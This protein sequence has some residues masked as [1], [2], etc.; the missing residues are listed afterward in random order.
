MSFLRLP[1]LLVCLLLAAAVSGAELKIALLC[2]GSTNDGG[3]NQLAREGAERLKAELGATVTVQQRVTADTAATAMKDFASDG[4]QLVIAHGYEFLNPAAATA[5]AVGTTRIAVSGADASRPG[6]VS[7]D[8][9]V[10]QASYQLGIIAGRLSRSGKLGFIGGG[11][12]PAVK[13]C[14]RGFLAGAHS[15]RP[16]ATVAEAYTSWDDVARN[17]AQAEAFIAQGIDQI[18]PDVDAA[19]RGIYEAVK[20][21]NMAHPDSLVWTY[22]CVG[23]ANANPAAGAWTLAS[24][25]IRLDNAFRHVAVMVRDGTWTEGV[26]REDLAS[27]TCVAVLNPA[28]TGGVLTSAIANEVA[29]AGKA[30]TSGSVTIP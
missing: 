22:G 24:A 25:V 20:E 28:L 4:Y 9:D 30:L 17:K 21:H 19:A 18:Y 8:F 16:D 11:N 15:V 26:I 12:F 10:S 13:A 27:N 29:A 7:I 5:T 6:I 14:Y 3:W 2:T 1:A 23:D